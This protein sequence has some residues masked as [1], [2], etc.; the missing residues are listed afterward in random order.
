M[1]YKR[2]LNLKT[3]L[4]KK[5]FFLFGPR[6]TGKTYLIRHQ[7]QD[8]IFIDLL[9][10]EVFLRL[11][12]HPSDIEALI[13]EDSGIHKVVV[14]DEV[15]KIPSILDEVHRLVES[16]G[17]RF[18]LTG[19]SARKLKRGHANLL[20]GRAWTAN[21]F[22][23]CW[24]EIENF[25]LERYLRYGGL[26]IVYQSEYPEEEL[27]AYVQ[28]YLK[29]EIAAEGLIRKLP[30][31]AR[32]LRVAAL[33]NGQILNLTQIG[34]DCHV[35]PS[36]VREYYSILEDTLL[37]FFLEPWTQSQV[38]KAVQTGKFYFFDLGVV[39]TLSGT[40]VL[41]RNSNLYGASFEHFIGAELRAYL[42][43][44]R[45]KK[46]LSFWRS[47]H[48]YEVD[49]LVG[50]HAAIEVKSTRRVSP[51]DFKGLM[52]LQEEGIFKEFYLVSQ[53]DID[54]IRNGVK[55]VYWE[56]FLKK[57][58]ADELFMCGDTGCRSMV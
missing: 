14:I 49:F 2:I 55:V 6:S 9:K 4:E 16:K 3:L 47:H 53:D 35:P 48:G 52:A 45:I 44:R 23:L 54:V 42:S 8:A 36:T 37:G 43:Y 32:F 22:P 11:L 29:E 19:S 38:R 46:T 24:A 1:K 30:P 34:S 51:H 21:M 15:Q 40:K 56:R 39:H 33:S 25:D 10:G 41:D 58:W 13:G 50:D 27:D 20:A 12:D 7:L 5:T 31:F 28:T 17:I 18:L 26:P 57:L